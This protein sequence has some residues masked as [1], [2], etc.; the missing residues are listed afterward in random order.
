MPE[1]SIEI[2]FLD[3]LIPARN[4]VLLWF[5]CHRYGCF[6]SF[7][8]SI[9]NVTME[10]INVFAM[11]FAPWGHNIEEQHLDNEP[12][13]ENSPGASYSQQDPE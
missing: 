8:T 9:N 3:M 11:F 4:S 7:Q 5:A 13:A 6:S 12:T 1:Q 2:L 10:K